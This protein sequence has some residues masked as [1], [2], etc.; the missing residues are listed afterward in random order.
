MASSADA[1]RTATASNRA[2]DGGLGLCETGGDNGAGA[3]LEAADLSPEDKADEDKCVAPRTASAEKAQLHSPLVGGAD[4]ARVSVAP[5][6]GAPINF[7][8]GAIPLSDARRDEGDA[9]D[10]AVASLA[11]DALVP[12]LAV[13]HSDGDT[14]CLRAVRAADCNRS[15]AASNTNARAFMRRANTARLLRMA[16]DDASLVAAAIAESQPQSKCAIDSCGKR[17][18]EEEL[19]RLLI[20]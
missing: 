15:V 8:R 5:S 6:L 20:W 9:L 14:R 11:A 10:A 19:R 7:D 18:R 13:T 2:A 4:T 3:G 12:A 16:A 17:M 1:F